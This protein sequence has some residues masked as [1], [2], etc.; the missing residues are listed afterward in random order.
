[1]IRR[2]YKRV[3]EILVD[4]AYR[5]NLPLHIRVSRPI[6]VAGEP[7]QVRIEIATPNG[8]DDTLITQVLAKAVES[9]VNTLFK[10]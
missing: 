7:T 3:A 4:D 10:I 2:I 1:M 5:N 9:Y 6:K 8:V